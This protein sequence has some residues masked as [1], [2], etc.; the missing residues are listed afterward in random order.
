MI[1]WRI[2][3]DLDFIIKNGGI[4]SPVWSSRI[5]QAPFTHK[6]QQLD[7]HP[8]TRTDLEELRSALKK[9]QL[10][11]GTR[12]LMI[13]IQKTKEENFHHA[14]IIPS[15]PVPRGNSS[16]RKSSHY[17]ERDIRV[18]DQLHQLLRTLHEGPTLVSPYPQ[19]SKAE[20]CT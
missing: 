20:M 9:L 5:T 6:D 2:P 15:Y 8:Q 1:R 18:N 14:S 12:K 17:Q 11:N 4:K 10:Q 3:P 19:T 7:S 13:I 16:S